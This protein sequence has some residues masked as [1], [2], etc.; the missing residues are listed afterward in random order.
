MLSST[1]SDISNFA[2]SVIID[3]QIIFLTQ[4]VSL[5]YVPLPNFICLCTVV[6]CLSLSDW[7][8]KKNCTHLP[9][10]FTFYKESYFNKICIFLYATLNCHTL[11]QDP[12]LSGTRVSPTSK[13]RASAVLFPDCRKSWSTRLGDLQWRNICNKF[14]KQRRT[15]PKVER[16]ITSHKRH[17][18]GISLIFPSREEIRPKIK[19]SLR[20]Q[21]FAIL[22]NCMH[23]VVDTWK[24]FAN[25]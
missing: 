5:S 20:I 17:G 7:T 3:L 25:F 15:G 1:A 18:E 11:F 21:Q 14:R 9:C 8:V 16:V 23:V 13:A 10:C 12:T 22:F 24:Y 19:R 4:S 2:I 6:R